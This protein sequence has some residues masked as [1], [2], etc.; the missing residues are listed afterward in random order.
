MIRIADVLLNPKRAKRH[1]IELILIA[2][3]YTSLSMFLGYWIFPEYSSLF[4]IFFSVISCVYVVQGI[5]IVEEKR[6]RDFDDEFI[7]LKKHMRTLKFLIVLFFGFLLAYVF[8]T[9]VLPERIGVEIFSIQKTEIENIRSITGSAINP[10][11]FTIILYN[12]FRVLVFSLILA[13]FYGAGSIFILVWNASIM[14]FVIGTLARNVVG[15][16]SL[17]QVFLKYF[18]HGLPEMIAYFIVALVGGILFIEII[19]GDFVKGKVKRTFIDIF[20]LLIIAIFLLV[21]AA[22]LE[23]YVSPLI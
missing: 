21:L 12:N 18:I 13:L 2:F 19:K 4:S 23:T 6:E 17:P 16:A 8:W 5:L 14:G 10:D 22:L 15:L 1:S 7:I 20:F 11:N 9:I 3:V